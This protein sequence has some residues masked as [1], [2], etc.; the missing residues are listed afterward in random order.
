VAV[1]AGE[2]DAHTRTLQSR[3]GIESG[4]QVIEVAWQVFEGIENHRHVRLSQFLGHDPGFAAA[5]NHRLHPIAFGEMDGLENVRRAIDPE[6][7]AA[8]RQ[9]PSHGV[10]TGRV[11]QCPVADGSFGMSFANGLF[12][13]HVLGCTRTARAFGAIAS[14]IHE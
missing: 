9:V 4:R 8:A 7:H 2:G 10:A 13:E 5:R 14:H 6:Y 3:G 1:S 11:Q 12:Q